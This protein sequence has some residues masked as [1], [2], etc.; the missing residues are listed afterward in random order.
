MT[1]NFLRANRTICCS[2]VPALVHACVRCAAY[3][4]ACVLA[5]ATCRPASREPVVR[6]L[7]ACAAHCREAY[8]KLLQ[9]RTGQHF[10][11]EKLV[12]VLIEHRWVVGLYELFAAVILQGGGD[13]VS[14]K[15]AWAEVGKRLLKAGKSVDMATYSADLKNYY[16]T[17]LRSF[18][19]AKSEEEGA[20]QALLSLRHA[21]SCTWEV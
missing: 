11:V 17:R 6:V 16:H 20:M 1:A 10:P 9:E 7:N 19:D 18:E 5:A 13:A 4:R 15:N 8:G 3:V 2:C 14:E 21:L 12:K